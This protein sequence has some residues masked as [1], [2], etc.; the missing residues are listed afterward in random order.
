MTSGAGAQSSSMAPGGGRRHGPGVEVALGHLA[1]EGPQPQRLAGG[2]DALGDEVVA[3]R[4]GHADD[5][6]DDRGVAVGDAEAGDE[7]AVDLDHVDREP[8]AGR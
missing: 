2:L 4:A 3:Q 5:G 8:A 7:R 1:P 6:G